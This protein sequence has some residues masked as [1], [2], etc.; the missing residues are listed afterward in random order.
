MA[1][2]P[3]DTTAAILRLRALGFVTGAIA[4]RVGVSPSHV[5]AVLA[6]AH[7]QTGKPAY[8]KTPKRKLTPEQRLAAKRV[9]AE[10]KRARAL[11]LLAEADSVLEV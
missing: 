4:V 2:Q 8:A 3:D 9:R 6:G 7:Q 10:A 11:R 1:T 5:R